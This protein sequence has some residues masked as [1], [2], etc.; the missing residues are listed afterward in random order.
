MYLECASLNIKKSEI[1]G[2]LLFLLQMWY[3]PERSW[4]ASDSLRGHSIRS[5]SSRLEFVKKNELQTVTEKKVYIS[6]HLP[7]TTIPWLTCIR[8]TRI[9]L[10][11]LFK[12][13]SFLMSYE[14]EIPSLARMP[15]HFY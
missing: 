4:T 14:K 13:F 9:S 3:V 1:I 15:F 6:R 7:Y 12:G 11:R 5:P 8:F 10:T 2:N